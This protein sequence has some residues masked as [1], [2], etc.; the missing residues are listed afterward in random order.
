MED[1][2]RLVQQRFGAHAQA[3]ASSAP[4]AQGDSLARVVELLAPQPEWN[5]VDVATG[6]GHM[7]LALAPHVREVIATDVTPQMLET[8][9]RLA[10]E[11]G[12]ANMR[13]KL[14]DAHAL[15]FRFQY[16]DAVT[17]RIAPHHFAHPGRFVAECA[18]I[19][20]TGGLLAIVDNIAPEEGGE[21]V[22]AFERL[23]DPS[24]VR[25]LT[26][27]EWR[28]LLDRRD[29]DLIAHETLPK[30]MDFAA[31]VKQQ[32]ASPQLTEQLADMLK[33]APASAAWWLRPEIDASG[34]ARAFTL[35]EGVYVARRR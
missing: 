9:R 6:A 14:A 11:R 20:K 32:R 4:H 24:H 23:R 30:R 28:A 1:L 31:W 8:A 16:A 29:F 18:R 10:Q 35:V 33:R 22:D 17:C 25:C 27:A 26:D 7:A 12:I 2:T 5:V 34:V 21:Y 13:Y 3:Y 19:L 15:P